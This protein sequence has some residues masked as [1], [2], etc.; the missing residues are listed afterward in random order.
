MNI[1][2]QFFYF[3]LVS[4]GFALDFTSLFLDEYEVSEPPFV[5]SNEYNQEIVLLQL[6]EI[7]RNERGVHI[8]F[9]IECNYKIMMIRRPS[10]AFLC[11]I[12]SRVHEFHK[13][14]KE[15]I[16]H[17]A[18]V[19]QVLLIL[20]KVFEEYKDRLFTNEKNFERVRAHFLDLLIEGDNFAYLK[21]M[22]EDDLVHFIYLNVLD[23]K[24]R[25]EKL[26]I[27][28]KENGYEID[29]V[30][31]SNIFELIKLSK[32]KRALFNENFS[33]FE[34]EKAIFIQANGVLEQ[35]LS[36]KKIASSL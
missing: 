5:I 24:N 32:K 12:N 15:I 21:K 7:P 25:F 20:E 35:R 9:S 6:S 14:F 22:F 36:F 33:S 18:D 4:R 30:Y 28:I 19:E 23:E 10:L 17:S 26:S 11:D 27:W 31:L 8:G 34:K 1:K 2:W 3:L 29:T 13:I 16:L